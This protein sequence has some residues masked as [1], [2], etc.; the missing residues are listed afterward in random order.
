MV[1]NKNMKTYHYQGHHQLTLFYFVCHPCPGSM[2]KRQKN[3]NNIYK[4]SKILDIV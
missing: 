4:L 2:D 3:E 1:L